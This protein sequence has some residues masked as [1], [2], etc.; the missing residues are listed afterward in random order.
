MA[1]RLLPDF[2]D[3]AD[4]GMIQSGSSLRFALEAAQ[5]LWI[6]GDLVGQEFQGDKAVQLQVLGLVNHAH[7][8]AAE[9]LDDAVVRDGLADHGWHVRSGCNVRDV[10][11][12]KS[13]R[14]THQ[15]LG[16][17]EASPIRVP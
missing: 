6:F 16:G 2:M 14:T 5:R 8:A 13:T 3:R 17:R 1:G 4:V 12:A 9:L 7:P 10:A 15:K 11:E